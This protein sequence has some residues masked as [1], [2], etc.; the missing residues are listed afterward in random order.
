MTDYTLT[1]SDTSSTYSV[2]ETSL[3]NDT[4]LEFIGHNYFKYGD[5]LQQNELHLGTNFYSLCAGK[6]QTEINALKAKMIPGQILYDGVYL[7]LKKNSSIVKLDLHS[8]NTLPTGN[9]SISGPH[10]AD[11]EDTVNLTALIDADGLPS[12]F[13]YQWK[14]DGVAVSGATSDK[15]T[16]VFADGGKKLS[17]TVTYTDLGGSTETVTSPEVT[18]TAVNTLPTG[19]IIIQGSKV[20]V[21][22]TKSIINLVDADGLPAP[23]TYTYEWKLDGTVVSTTDSYTPVFGDLGKSLVVKLSYTDLHG[24]AESL[25][26]TPT[27]ITNDPFSATMSAAATQTFANINLT[28]KPFDV[29][30]G[31]GVYNYTITPTSNIQAGTFSIDPD[32]T[33]HYTS[34]GSL[35]GANPNMNPPTT[36]SELTVTVT[37]ANNSASTYSIKY[38]FEEFLVLNAGDPPL[39]PSAWGDAQFKFVIATLSTTAAPIS[40]AYNMYS[41]PDPLILLV[42]GVMVDHTGT[43]SNIP[44]YVSGVT[45]IPNSFFVSGTSGA[46]P[47]QAPVS[48]PL[49]VDSELIV[50]VGA[51]DQSK[52][53]IFV[54]YD[55]GKLYMKPKKAT[56]P[57]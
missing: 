28:F 17:I 23:A 16:P 57:V 29:S 18:I 42:D 53:D 34:Q 46:S 50:D 30:G 9:I 7:W 2:L 36:A 25:T 52:W 14:L 11:S 47:I 33:L 39:Q 3:N 41:A 44:N 48:T 1:K 20:G 19:S 13:T 22:L 35:P 24:T 51:S 15:F 32:G 38:T 54:S 10:N 49:L 12:T 56:T 21:A 26:S 8:L 27:V 55:N 37:D 5:V 45:A 40:I 6:S 31:S 4:L 43:G